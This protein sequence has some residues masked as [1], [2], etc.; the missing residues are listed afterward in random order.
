MSCSFF[1]FIHFLW[2]VLLL[3]DISVMI[4]L[5]PP[6]SHCCVYGVLTSSFC[7][8]FLDENCLP[9]DSPLIFWQLEGQIL[10]TIATCTW[11]CV[12]QQFVVG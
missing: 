8:A 1:L 12:L 7:F 9:P 10:K 6:G 2:P 4:C 5:A 11:G 3:Q